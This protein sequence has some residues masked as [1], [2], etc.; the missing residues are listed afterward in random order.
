MGKR[1]ARLVT[2]LFLYYRSVI[3]ETLTKIKDMIRAVFKT[4]R[5]SFIFPGKVFL[6][7]PREIVL[8]ATNIPHIMMAINGRIQ[9]GK[10]IIPS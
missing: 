3:A 10:E 5:P 7:S 9:K 6:Y 2:L 8:I 4:A 1:I